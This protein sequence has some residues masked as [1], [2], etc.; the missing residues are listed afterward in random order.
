[1]APTYSMTDPHPCRFRALELGSQ[2]PRASSLGGGEQGDGAG[3]GL[4]P[5]SKLRGSKK[6]LCRVGVVECGLSSP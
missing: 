4:A 1:M 6:D 2:D 3:V 5:S